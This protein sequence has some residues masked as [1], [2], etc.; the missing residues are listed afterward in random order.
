[1][2]AFIKV[3]LGLP[4]WAY[5]MAAM[6]AGW[7]YTGY[8]LG[9]VKDERNEAEK[10]YAALVLDVEKQKTTAATTLSKETQKVADAQAEL[11]T[12]RA[13]Q[14]TKDYQN[15][16]DRSELE[17]KLRA[18]TA[19]NGGRLRDPNATPAQCRSSGGSANAQ[20]PAP[21][22]G[23]AANPAETDGVLSTQLTGL[24]RKLTLEADEINDAYIACKPDGEALRKKLRELSP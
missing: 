9:A 21:A 3:I 15:A 6:L 12:L 11:T 14:E 5:V 17:G 18:A 8:R 4:W 23:G 16:K 20:S 22:N 13:E 1:M 19:A 10:L 7:L 24:L 2:T